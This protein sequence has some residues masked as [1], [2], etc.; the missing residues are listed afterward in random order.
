[1]CVCVFENPSFLPL[2]PPY[3]L[4][5][6]FSVPSEFPLGDLPERYTVEGR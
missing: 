6:T 4:F 5:I 2:L 3:S 1:M